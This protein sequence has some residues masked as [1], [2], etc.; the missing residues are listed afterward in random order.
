ME[1]LHFTYIHQGWHPDVVASWSTGGCRA[2]IDRRLGYRFV[3]E[4]AEFPEAARAGQAFR[5]RLVLRNEGW[6]AMINP[7]P[8]VLLLEGGGRREEL[9]LEGA[10]PRRWAPGGPIE[11]EAVLPAG[12]YRVLLWLPDAA[13]RLRAQSDY[14]VRLAD[15]GLWDAVLGANLLGT[16]TLD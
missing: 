6:A 2:E 7:R 11:V 3:L 13:E 1:R 5:L 4:S 14:A 12:A 8:V 16:L 10:D 9:A 15:E